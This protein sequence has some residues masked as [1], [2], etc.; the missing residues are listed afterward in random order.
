MKR[1]SYLDCGSEG[2]SILERQAW[3]QQSESES[4]QT[5]L[6]QYTE[7]RNQMG[8]EVRL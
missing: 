6:Q 5:S 7:N 2:E 3:P 4:E 1:R 8:S